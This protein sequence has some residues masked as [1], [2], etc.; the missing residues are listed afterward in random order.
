MHSSSKKTWNYEMLFLQTIAII[1]MVIGHVG[2]QLPLMTDAFYPIYSWHMPLFVFIS[3]YFLSAREGYGRFVWRKCKRLLLPALGVRFALALLAVVASLSGLYE[4]GLSLD[5]YGMLVDPFVMC[6]AY[7]L[8]NAMWFIFQL[9][10]LEMLMGALIRIPSGHTPVALAGCLLPI[11]LLSVYLAI[12][13]PPAGWTIP[14]L[15]T[16]YL[17]FFMAAGY[18]YRHKPLFGRVRP[19]C[20]LGVITAVQATFLLLSGETLSFS[21]HPMSFPDTASFLIPFLA[22]VNGIIALLCLAKWLAPVLDKSRFCLWVGSGTKAVLYFHELCLL[23]INCVYM[24]LWHRTD[25][26]LFQGFQPDMVRAAWYGFSLGGSPLGQLPYLVLSLVLPIGITRLLNR[27]PK[28][29]KRILLWG[30]L[31]IGLALF[32]T[33]MGKYAVEAVGL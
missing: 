31:W 32:L 17:A 26:A 23:L 29:W 8:S 25:S 12:R 6:E 1:A 27:P 16:G 28:F 33:M 5:L 11:S 4:R 2:H 13:Q 20:V 10:L 21:V 24:V 3:G 19:W 14:L 22:A 15:R 7:P 9:F 30:A 18:L